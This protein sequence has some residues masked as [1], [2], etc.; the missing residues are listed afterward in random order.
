MRIRSH[1]Q[2]SRPIP[3]PTRSITDDRRLGVIGRLGRRV[4]RHHRLVAILWL[5]IILAAGYLNA[6]FGGKTSDSFTVPGTDS[7][8]AYDLLETDFPSQNAATAT[9]VFS[10]PAGQTLSTP[11]NAAAVQAA[12]TALQGVQGVNASSVTDPLT[13]PTQGIADVPSPVSADGQ[14]GYTRLAF[15]DTIAALLEQYPTNS[16]KPATAYPNP[17]NQ[18]RTAIA[19]LPPSDVTVTIGGPVADVYNNEVSWWASHADEVGLGLGAVLLLIAFGSV[20]GMAIP[21]ATA[22]FGAITAGGMVL[23]LADFITVSSAAPN[24][25]LMIAIGVGLDYSLLIVTRYRQFLRDGF[26]P[27]DAAGLALA[28]AGRAALFAGIT[29][30]VALLGLLLVPIPLVQTL[31]LAAAI[32]VGVMITAA[33]TLLPALLGMAGHRI[34]A[35]RL[36]FALRESS[37]DPARSFWGRFAARVGRRPWL[38]LLVGTA[39]LLICARPFLSIDFGMPDDSSLPTSLS[40]QQA[41]TLIEQ[42][43]GPGANSPLIVVA[44][45]PGATPG[46]IVSSLAPLS[47]ALGALQPA[48]TVPGAEYSVGPIPNTAGDAAVYQIIPTDGPDS[49]QTRE[50]VADLRSRISTAT[51]GTQITAHVGGTTATLIDLTELVVQY[52]PWVIGAVVLG[53]FVLLLLVFRSI[54]VPLKAAIMNLISIAAAYGIVVVVFQWGWA[55]SLIGL[56]STIPIVSFVPL[57]MFV[58]LFGLSMDYEVFLMSRIRE[59]WD[60]TGDPTQSVVLGVANTA[61]VIT[62]AA[63]IMIAVF[64][65]FVSIQNPTVQV[66]GFGMAVAVLL[67]STIVRMVLVPAVMEILDARAWWFPRW[68]GWLPKLDIEGAPGLLA[69]TEEQ[70]PAPV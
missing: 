15:D 20:F 27:D 47:T 24:V 43:F 51:A 5:L 62:T 53:A 1:R 61:R 58:I 59:E 34:D 11:A 66:L 10:V 16:E 69:D 52:L 45:V 19:A 17:Y 40:Q 14:I 38:T 48:G 29:V 12:I 44:S 56:H 8:A 46:T 28:T 36:P 37:E 33:T 7:Q 49:S 6:T 23:L 63:L 18:L 31:G 39:V 4:S 3:S 2:G 65:S 30:A 26:A 57:I 50:L 21:I 22:L 68:L 25:T 54:L 55:K 35:Y 42:G 41:F 13:S 60:L 64:S 9:I 70:E 32:G 67:D